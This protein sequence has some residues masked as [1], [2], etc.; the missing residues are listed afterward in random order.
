MLA[1]SKRLSGLVGV[2]LEKG[3]RVNHSNKN[4]ERALGIAATK[5]LRCTELL[6]GRSSAIDLNY[7]DRV[8]QQNKHGL[9]IPLLS[10]IED[11]FA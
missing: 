1:C 8:W 2:L 9:S 7:V 6:V 3:V 10:L 5:D 4:G 11:V